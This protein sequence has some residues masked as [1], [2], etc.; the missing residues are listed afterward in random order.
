MYLLIREKVFTY[1]YNKFR[2]VNR[3]HYMKYG[4]N[5]SLHDSGCCG[6]SVAPWITVLSR[7][8]NSQKGWFTLSLVCDI[9]RSRAS[10]TGPRHFWRTYTLCPF[11]GGENTDGIAVGF[12]ISLAIVCYG[13]PQVVKL[14][15]RSYLVFQPI[16]GQG[17]LGSLQLPQSKSSPERA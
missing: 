10:C 14:F 16:W 13:D 15:L 6:R 12:I 7:H 8:R 3:T 17:N 9:P 1:F 5:S 2:T 4:V 11:F